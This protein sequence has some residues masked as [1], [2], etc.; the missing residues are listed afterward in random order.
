[1]SATAD[2][3]AGT[4]AGEIP[5]GW[6]LARSVAIR[7]DDLIESEDGRWLWSGDFAGH[8]TTPAGLLEGKLRVIRRDP[9][10]GAK[11]EEPQVS[12]VMGL[13]DL[14]REFE[15]GVAKTAR[16]SDRLRA[17]RKRHAQ[18]EAKLKAQLDEAHARLDRAMEIVQYVAL[19]DHI[20]DWGADARVT[21]LERI[22]KQAQTLVAQEKV[23]KQT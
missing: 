8:P 3:L 14:L 11:G 16:A 15:R 6:S 22:N 4:P 13:G 23:R 7:I 9:V 1:M 17:Q 18:R 19:G 12:C 21:I 2:E 20:R 10:P 5:D